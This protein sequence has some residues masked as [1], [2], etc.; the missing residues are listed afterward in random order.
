MNG[1]DYWAL[2]KLDVMDTLPKIKICVAYELDGKQ[3]D[4]MPS[5]SAELARVKP[6]YEEM[7]GWLCETSNITKIEDLPPKAKAYVDR[8]MELSGAKLGIL[9]IGPA[10]ES[11]LRIAL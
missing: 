6:V 8:L 5:S 4:Y 9:S 3:I 7:D 10:R 2:T 1:I 11:T